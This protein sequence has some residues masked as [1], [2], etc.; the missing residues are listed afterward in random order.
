MALINKLIVIFLPLVPKFVVYLFAKRYIAGP[1]LGDAINVIKEFSAKKMVAT[2][3]ILGEEVEQKADSLKVVE[4]YKQALSEI[5]SNNLDANISVKPTH[6]GLKIDKEFCYDNIRDLLVEAKKFNNYVR[7]DMED[8]TCTT[9]TLEIYS[10]LHKEFDN[11][12]VVIQAYLRRTIDDVNQLIREK[13][14][15][16]LCKGIYVEPSKIAYK[17]YD[18][19]NNNFQYSLKKLLQN[20]CYI[21]IATHDE[22]LIWHALSVID[23]LKL[24][25][26]DYEFQM[27]LG[28]TE[29]LRDMLVENGHHL[30]IYVPFGEHWYAY[31][32][33]RL[34]EN[35]KVAMYI[36]KHIFNSK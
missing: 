25:K 26:S 29:D 35:P 16:R 15:L 2:L 31:S 6:L 19:I 32:M 4:E 33:R 34:K 17:D 1:T 30:R 7:I 8:H 5:D 14:N 13:A 11:V 22:I 10:R 36:I 9:D 23:E 24:E 20:K 21:G 3:D 27:L 12:G 18:I 28:V